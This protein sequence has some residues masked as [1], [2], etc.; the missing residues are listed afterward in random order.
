MALKEEKKM[1][2]PKRVQKR[3]KQ[4]LNKYRKQI[5]KNEDLQMDIVKA[6]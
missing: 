2:V 5:K 3:Y 1:P 6:A 4:E